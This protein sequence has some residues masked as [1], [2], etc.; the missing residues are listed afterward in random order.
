MD[1]AFDG[2]RAPRPDGVI[3]LT[4]GAGGN[5]LYDPQF[6]GRPATWLRPEDG[7]VAYVE[8]L[9]ADRH[10]LTVVDM[11]PGELVVRQVDDQGRELDRI[12]IT[13]A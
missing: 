5:R 13:R 6:T 4:T 12:R 3:Y 10:S 11:Q 1:T 2:R 9:V 7:K 8:R